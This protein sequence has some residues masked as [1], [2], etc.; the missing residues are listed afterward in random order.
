[1]AKET[2][3]IFS[4]DEWKSSASMSYEVSVRSISALKKYLES[5]EYLKK[6]EKHYGLWFSVVF[7]GYSSMRE[8]V[9]LVN[10]SNILLH[11]E[12]EKTFK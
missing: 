4:C 3:L 2:F 5:S 8:L 6:R 7:K 12:L 1:M 11:I 9:V 10:E